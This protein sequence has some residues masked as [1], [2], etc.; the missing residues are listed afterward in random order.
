MHR[1]GIKYASRHPTPK[2]VRHAFIHAKSGQEFQWIIET[3]YA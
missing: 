2:I 1:F 3:Y